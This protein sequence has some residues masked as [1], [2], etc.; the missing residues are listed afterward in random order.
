MA[1]TINIYDPK[2]GKFG[3]LS[4][5]HLNTLEI[6]GETWRSPQNYIYANLLKNK[7]YKEQVKNVKKTSKVYDIYKKMYDKSIDEALFEGYFNGYKSLLEKNPE[8]SA[9][10]LQ[11]GDKKIVYRS[12]NTLIGSNKNVGKNI[13]GTVLESL[14]Y[15]IKNILSKKSQQEKLYK[16]YIAYNFLKDL[17]YDHK[18]IEQFLGK[19]FEEFV[20]DPNIIPPEYRTDDFNIRNIDTNSDISITT[21][22]NLD[23]TSIDNVINYIKKTEYRKYRQEIYMEKRII[24]LNSYLEYLVETNYP[25][26]DE[27]QKIIAIIETREQLSK[28]NEKDILDTIYDSYKENLLPKDLSEKIDNIIHNEKKLPDTPDIKDVEKAENII[29]EKISTQDPLKDD[30]DIDQIKKNKLGNIKNILD[31]L[32]LQTIPLDSEAPLYKKINNIATL[33]QIINNDKLQYFIEEIK[34]RISEINELLKDDNS[35]NEYNELL[36]AEDQLTKE[37]LQNELFILKSLIFTS[38][39]NDHIKISDIY[40]P[41]FNKDFDFNELVQDKKREIK[42]LIILEKNIAKKQKLVDKLQLIEVSES[43]GDPKKVK[44]M[45]I[46]L[47]IQ[48]PDNLFHTTT[49]QEINA[50]LSPEEIKDKIIKLDKKLQTDIQQ[51]LEI[52]VMLTKNENIKKKLERVKQLNLDLVNAQRLA[53]QLEQTDERAHEIALIKENISKEKAYRIYERELKKY[54]QQRRQENLS[55]EKSQSPEPHKHKRPVLTKIQPYSEPIIVGIEGDLLLTYISGTQTKQ[56]IIKGFSPDLDSDIIIDGL[57]YKSITHYVITVLYYK[58]ILSVKTMED[59]YTKILTPLNT[60]K[61]IQEISVDYTNAYIEDRRLYTERNCMVAMN[62][63]FNTD[64][65]LIKLLKSTG[66]AHIIYQDKQDE[67]LGVGP[68]NNGLNFVGKYLEYLRQQK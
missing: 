66:S 15:R 61:S 21:I 25:D 52:Y 18:N 33:K 68:T 35:L 54:K 59:A 32:I 1:H 51:N 55:K 10:L 57:L 45:L 38:S 49:Y 16:I 20:S 36:K 3:P 24:V 64:K 34:N 13:I 37:D 41:K 42:N 39:S 58:M 63:K 4:N 60:F 67:I 8:L 17:L 43:S 7:L 28:H 27:R 44:E 19:D 5:L 56:D 11:A 46:T 62:E 31:N 23:L 40:N 6:E 48:I 14:R 2:D 26:L 22:Y 50:E 53:E 30:Y 9:K 65:K 12:E 29:F 47:N